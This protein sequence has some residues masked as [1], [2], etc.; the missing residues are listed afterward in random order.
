MET[1]TSNTNAN[2]KEYVKLRDSKS[3]RNKNNLFV[4]ESVK[5]LNEAIDSGIIIKKA[6]VTSLS[7]E[8]NYEIL[9]SLFEK[10]KKNT[11]KAKLYEITQ[12]I[13][14]KLTITGNSQGVFA[15]C[16]KLDKNDVWDTINIQGKYVFLSHLQ[17]TGNVGT[18]IRTALALGLNGI[19]VS[20]DTC[21]LYSLKVLRAS[22]GSVF[23]INWYESE[24]IVEDLRQLSK[25]FK[26]YAAVLDDTATDLLDVN[27]SKNSIIVIGNEGNGLDVE[28]V[29]ACTN[30]ITIS[31]KGNA[32]SLNAG[33]A[34]SI[35][36]WEMMKNN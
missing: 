32:E 9:Q 36:M 13:E 20:K 29:S 34:S 35:L 4:V 1:I 28:E 19:I 23:R 8:K 7:K 31:M 18:I 22:M 26:T 6:F 21:D 17:D 15:V 30:K 14:K 33:I 16:E 2:I 27:F 11:E 3:F 25:H 5:L 10:S 24:N 12:D